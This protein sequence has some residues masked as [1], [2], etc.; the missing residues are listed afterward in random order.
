MGGCC[1]VRCHNAP[2]NWQLGWRS[3]MAEFNA[4]TMP[5]HK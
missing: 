2:H 1:D 5:L 4:A 3:P